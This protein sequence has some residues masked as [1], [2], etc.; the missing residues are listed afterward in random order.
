MSGRTKTLYCEVCGR[1]TVHS[2]TFNKTAALVTIFTL[3]LFLIVWPVILLFGKH[4]SCR[5]CGHLRSTGLLS[6]GPY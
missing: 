3:G 2:T 1:K 4:W 6:R 5:R